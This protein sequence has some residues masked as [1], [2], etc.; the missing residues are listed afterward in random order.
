MDPERTSTVAFSV[1]FSHGLSECIKMQNQRLYEVG[2]NI[3]KHHL[4]FLFLYSMIHCYCCRGMV[5]STHF[6]D[7]NK[8][9]VWGFYSSI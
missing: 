5:F 1:V 2:G 7:K 3:G 9:N 8:N 4:S 6:I